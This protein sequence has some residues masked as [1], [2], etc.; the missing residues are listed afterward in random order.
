[1][2]IIEK[3]N[4]CLKFYFK[5]SVP[6]S[7]MWEKLDKIHGALD[8]FYTAL[9]CN[10]LTKRL[11]DWFFTQLANQGLKTNRNQQ[12]IILANLRVYVMLGKPNYYVSDSDL[13]LIESSQ[14]ESLALAKMM[15]FDPNR[16]YLRFKGS[17]D[18]SGPWRFLCGVKEK[19]WY[20]P[21]LGKTA[22][23]T[24]WN[25]IKYIED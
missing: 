18:L 14:N 19:R 3:S 7:I 10:K 17:K 22:V 25:V 15:N 2:S 20:N 11:N 21:E 5:L 12:K 23:S 24:M 9:Q 6:A 13:Q 4:L 16:M 8:P 1:M